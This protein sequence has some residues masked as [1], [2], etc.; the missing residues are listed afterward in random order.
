MQLTANS[1]VNQTQV[2]S[3]PTVSRSEKWPPVAGAQIST[4]PEVSS[5]ASNTSLLST[6]ST[7]NAVTIPYVILNLSLD[8]HI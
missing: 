8:A 5:D 4:N 7:K 6:K 2:D 3:V 1:Q